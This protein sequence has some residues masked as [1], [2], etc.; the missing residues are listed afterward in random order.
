MT[1]N[2]NMSELPFARFTRTTAAG[3]PLR[4]SPPWTWTALAIVGVATIGALIASWFI[5]IEITGRARGIVRPVSG[6]RSLAARTDGTVADVLIR[7]GDHVAAGTTVIRLQ[8]ADVEASLLESTRDLAVR[9]EDRRR[10]EAE[11]GYL[12]QRATLLERLNIARSQVGSFEQSTARHKA[13][14]E[15]MEKLRRSGLISGLQ[16]DEAEEQ[17][18][19]AQRD[20]QAARDAEKRTRQELAAID[21]ARARELR[22]A[23]ARIGEARARRESIDLPAQKGAVDTP[24]AGTIEGLV[25]RR[26]DVVHAGQTLA[27]LMPD[28]A[29]LHIVAFLPERDR[30]FVHAGSI[31]QLEL[32]QYPYA[33]FGTIPARVTRVGAD[34][35]STYEVREAF[36]D[37]ATDDTR[38]QFR[39]E[40]EVAR[41]HLRTLSIRPGMMLNVRLT[42]RR[43]RV[44]A[45]LFA[46]LQRWSDGA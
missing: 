23:D 19:A 33:E 3:L 10:I 41:E 22:E 17:Y 26:G 45:L 25:I 20:A 35:A 39:V 14:M 1:H 34:L 36:G 18:A 30:A 27:K 15:A 7:S 11:D 46:P 24:V 5:H 12:Q 28:A 37:S 6:I 2:P 29:T 31:A 21:A 9:E 44:L 13:H 40:L 16:T 4:V 8:A 43:Q 38:A 42:L 32:D